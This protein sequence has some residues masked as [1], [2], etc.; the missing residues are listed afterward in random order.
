MSQRSSSSWNS[1]QPPCSPRASGWRV[2][3][4]CKCHPDDGRRRRGQGSQ[5]SVGKGLQSAL[6]CLAPLEMVKI[7]VP[8][9]PHDRWDSLDLPWRALAS[10]TWPPRSPRANPFP[11]WSPL[12]L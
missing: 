3:S 9:V 6:L 11:P 10:S 1:D 7:R 5:P 8:H 12:A 4:A 2:P